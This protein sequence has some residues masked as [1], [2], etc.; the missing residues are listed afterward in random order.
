MA[1]IQISVTEVIDAPPATVYDILRDYEKHPAIL[2]KPE[3]DSLTVTKGG[4]GEGTEFDMTMVIMGQTTH[5]H[6]HVTEPEPGHIL[7]EADPESGTVTTF[8]VEPAEGG[9]KSRVTFDTELRASS[10]IKGMV[11][12]LLVPRVLRSLYHRE[13][14]NLQ[15]YVTA[16][17]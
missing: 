1:S 12:K 14:A 11:E 8:I 2:P 4:I 6:F 13:F 5:S 16:K 3:F 9:Q 7:R 10:G 15:N 17:V